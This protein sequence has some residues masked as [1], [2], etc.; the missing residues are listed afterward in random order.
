MQSWA[1][2]EGWV[3][4]VVLCGGVQSRPALFPSESAWLEGMTDA[5]REKNI[6][7]R[8]GRSDNAKQRRRRKL[9]GKTMTNA[10]K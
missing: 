6:R 3:H 8:A 7:K 5:V 9:S 10:N 1:E 4:Q 2:H